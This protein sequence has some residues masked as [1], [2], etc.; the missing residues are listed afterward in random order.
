MD[1]RSDTFQLARQ[2]LNAMENLDQATAISY[3][4][5]KNIDPDEFKA[6]NQKLLSFLEEG[7]DK[8]EKLRAEGKTE[9]AN[10]LINTKKYSVKPEGFRVGRIGR[11]LI[12]EVGSD[13]KGI[14]STILPGP[15]RAISKVVGDILPDPVEDMIERTFDPYMGEGL[16]SDASRM[17]ADI[18]SF[19]VPGKIIKYGVY[20]MAPG[21]IATAIGPKAQRAKKMVERLKHYGSYA[22]GYTIAEDSADENT[23]NVMLDLADEYAGLEGTEV[24]SLLRKFAVNPD[25]SE[26][27]QKLNSLAINLSGVGAFAGLARL[28]SPLDRARALEK[29]KK[30]ADKAKGQKLRLDVIPTTGLGKFADKIGIR[31][32]LFRGFGTTRGTDRFTRDRIIQR[33][34]AAKKTIKEVDGLIQTLQKE[35][36]SAS[37]LG[38]LKKEQLDN[39]IND[40]LNGNKKSL[41]TLQTEAPKV[42]KLANQ[43]FKNIKKSR[44]LASGNIKNVTMKNKW[45]PEKKEVWLNRSYR[46]YDDPTFSRDIK[47]IPHDVRAGVEHYLRT[48]LKIPPHLMEAHIKKLLTRGNLEEKTILEVFNP[49]RPK[50]YSALG[51]PGSSSKIHLPRTELAKVKAI[52]ALWGEVK[53]P[54]KNYYNSMTKLSKVEADASFLNDMA[55]YLKANGLAKTADQI[56]NRT[57]PIIGDWDDWAK[58]IDDPLKSKKIVPLTVS[59]EGARGAFKGMA[60]DKENLGTAILKN[61]FGKNAEKNVLN[62]LEGLYVNKNYKDFLNEGTDI[63]APNSAFMQNWMRY[64]VATQTAKTIYNPSTHG[65]NTMGNMIMMVANGYNPFKYKSGLKAAAEKLTGKSNLELG[66]RL[67]RYQE[68]AITDSGV[69]QEVIRRAAN[70]VFKFEGKGVLAKA[71]TAMNAKANPLKAA[72]NLYQVEDDFFKIMHFENTINQLKKVFPKGT[73]IDVIERE[74]ARRTRSLMPNYNLVGKTLKQ[75]RYMPVG[76][77]MSFPAEMVRISKNLARDTLHDISGQTARRL[78]IQNKAGQKVLKNMG[79]RRLG[80]MTSAAVAGDEAMNYSANLMGLT[81]D[82]RDALERVQPL[83][84]QGTAKIFLSGVNKDKNLHTGIDYINLGPIDPFSYL[85]APVR[86]IAKELADIAERGIVKGDLGVSEDFNRRFSALLMQTGGAFLGSSMSAEALGRAYAIFDDDKLNK[87][88]QL[89]EGAKIIAESIAPGALTMGLK[90]QKYRTSIKERRGLRG[91]YNSKT[92]KYEARGA[93]SDADYTIPEVE[94]EAF[95]GL[96][97]WFGIRPQRLDITAGMRRHIFPLTMGMDDSKKQLKFMGNPNAPRDTEERRKQFMNAYKYDQRKRLDKQRKLKI[98]VDAYDDLGLDYEDI[99][100]GLSKEFLREINSTDIVKK[101][102]FASR[103]EFFPSMFPQS[104]IA[105]AEVYTGGPLPYDEIGRLYEQLFDFDLIEEY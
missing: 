75:M 90:G 67:G 91:R 70:Q 2:D 60:A 26:A 83:W 28:K 38:R 105:E 5:S 41:A 66:K 10:R 56:E 58:A 34:G 8:I 68:L 48:K 63:L 61:S 64:K 92:G 43:M 24:S 6:A 79:Y 12:G 54:Y 104:R 31:N 103:N 89:T 15:T 81:S 47:K 11:R 22:A 36:T 16:G 32:K 80:G 44:K 45:D 13:I 84:E 74:A 17:A 76:D 29:I 30:R 46:I 19:F 96:P 85:K 57:G 86:I 88:E 42:A 73:S 39:L 51:R 33:E 102:G 40:V 101:M 20:A 93:V 23:Y 14:A 65:R 87:K 35:V 50:G 52:R 82:D 62:P 4:Q 18:A 25:D 3:L 71:Q 98:I 37:R 7:K 78:G 1:F 53:D 99:L 55:K 9:E 77:F 94:M 100:S 27:V 95:G 72:Q 97:R 49:L 69:K 59:E 21:K